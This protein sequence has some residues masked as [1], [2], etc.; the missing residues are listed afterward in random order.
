MLSV[1]L[2]RWG[3]EVV[4]TEDGL[5]AL[6]A[7]RKPD[8]PRL[9]IVDWMMP[10]M[11][12]LQLCKTLQQDRTET[13]R[14]VIMLTSR[15]DKEDAVAALD[16]G[17]DD[18]LTKPYDMAELRARVNVGARIVDLQTRLEKANAELAH[19]ART[20]ALTQT[21]NRKA[22]L[23]TLQE[24]LARNERRQE[25]LVVMMCDLDYFK[26]V[27]DTY[28][29]VCGDRVLR[30]TAERLHSACRAYDH[31]G[32]Y[33]GEEFLIVL[34]G[35]PPEAVEIIGDRFLSRITAM[36]YGTDF[37]A[38]E[39]TASFGILWVPPSSRTTAE[40]ALHAVDA[41]LYEAK[42]RG[43]NQYVSAGPDGAPFPTGASS[44]PP[45]AGDP[46]RSA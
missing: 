36:P 7:L 35:P 28:G 6:D 9:A 15:T 16:A 21:L 31:V 18:Y 34:G 22:I 45:P 41:L 2:E 17:A 26:K 32:R 5:Q 44:H 4:S 14:Y 43:R 24:E 11:D 3:H 1:N 8:A 20:D 40:A 46:G 19:T 30:E 25:G 13:F 29:H 12:G 38:I 39:V 42:S 23:D 37:G 33:G 27:N 10:A